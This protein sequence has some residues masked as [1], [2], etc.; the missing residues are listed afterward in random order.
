MKY[1]TYIENNG[2]VR[3]IP[4]Q[5]LPTDGEVS[6]DIKTIHELLDKL[7]Q[8]QW[9]SI[10]ELQKAYD[11]A[12]KEFNENQYDDYLEGYMLGLKNAIAIIESDPPE[13]NES[14]G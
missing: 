2:N 3:L 1:R 8:Y 14:N 7:E 12:V 13:R 11:E 6:H 4:V 10:K 9:R 5:N